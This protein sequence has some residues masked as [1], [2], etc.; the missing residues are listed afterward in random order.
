MYSTIKTSIN[1]KEIARMQIGVSIKIESKS[2]KTS[3]LGWL[4][5]YQ[6]TFSIRE[7]LDHIKETIIKV[8][9]TYRIFIHKVKAIPLIESIFKHIQIT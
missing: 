8:N 6:N 2:L 7:N 1:I 4:K 3:G 9:P 5:I